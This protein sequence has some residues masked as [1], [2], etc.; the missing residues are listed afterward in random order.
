MNM[1][2]SAVSTIFLLEF[3]TDSIVFLFCFYLYT[4]TF[5]IFLRFQFIAYYGNLIHSRLR[6]SLKK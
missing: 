6:N 5:M 2:V 1:R 4:N 3:G